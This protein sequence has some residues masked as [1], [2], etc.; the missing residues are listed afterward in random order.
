MTLKER[1]KSLAD[2]RGISLP[3]LES[4]LGFGNSTIVKWDKP[5]PN[6][7]KLKAVAEYFGVSMDYLMGTTNGWTTYPICH[8]RYDPLNKYDSKAHDRFHQKYIDAE[9][10]Y[11]SLISY[12]EAFEK[13]N[14]SI[15][16]FKKPGLTLEERLNGYKQY[17]K[18]DFIVSL[19]KK[20][21]NLNHEDFETFCKKGIGL[22]STKEALDELDPALY[23]ALVLVMAPELGHAILRRKENC[24]FIR[25]KTL[26]L[27]SKNEI[28]ANKFAM[29]LLIDDSFLE[30]NK[31][32][33]T[34]QLAHVLGYYEKLIELRLKQ[35]NHSGQD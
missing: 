1:V 31:H 34:G 11:G 28:E 19:Q 22:A 2:M 32:L 18:Y 27:T 21:L 12:G 25:N 24:Y 23:Q 26:L 9:S 30:E 29:V 4:R 33:T 7:G 6:A 5:T 17:L 13:R 35:L 16:E 10:K 20:N 3:T 15:V 8:N 14:D